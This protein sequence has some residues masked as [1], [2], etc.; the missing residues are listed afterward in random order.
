ML[1]FGIGMH[2]L[3]YRFIR[4]V[5][6]W[7]VNHGQFKITTAANHYYNRLVDQI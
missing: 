7:L 4:T 1:G 6:K 2:S 5:G 3:N